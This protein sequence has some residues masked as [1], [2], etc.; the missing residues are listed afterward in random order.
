MR[1]I[2]LALTVIALAGCAMSP[3]K[4]NHVSLG[5][6]KPTVMKLLG[7]PYST[8][9]RGGVEVLAYQV[10]EFSH[11]EE[12]WVVL[13]QG[14]VTQYGRAN[15]LSMPTQRIDLNVTNN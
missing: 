2:L 13:E 3:K 8:K 14:R 4:F 15:E 10:D 9:A 7:E 11:I 1:L 6:D 5:M 12:Y